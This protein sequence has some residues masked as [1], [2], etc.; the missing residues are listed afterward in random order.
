MA[1]P[2]KASSPLPQ[3]QPA[4]LISMMRHEVADLLQTVYYAVPV[5]QRRLPEDWKVEQGLLAVLRRRAATCRDMID[6][7]GDFV[8]PLTIAHDRVDLAVVVE[9]AARQMAADFPHLSVHAWPSKPTYLTG[10]LNRLRQLARSL[11]LHACEAAERRIET[12]LCKSSE[13]H[14][15]DWIVRDDG[16]KILPDRLERIFSPS[17]ETRQGRTGIGLALA[18]KIAQMHGGDVSAHNRLDGGPEICVRLPMEIP[19]TSLVG[20]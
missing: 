15:V 12:G 6:E 11:L 19:S 13:P 5:L 7:V 20:V 2:D 14:R 1:N 4:Q 10:D 8:N 17:Y 16:A 3:D 9:E 18:R